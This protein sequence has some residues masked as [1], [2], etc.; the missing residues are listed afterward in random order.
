MK[1]PAYN[2]LYLPDMRKNQAEMFEMACIRHPE[3]DTRKLITEFMRSEYHR[4]IDQG[5][6]GW[7]NMPPGF[8]LKRYLNWSGVAPKCLYTD[9]AAPLDSLTAYWIGAIYALYQWEYAI[10]SAELVV[11][12]DVGDMEH[13]FKLLHT[14]GEVKAV[15]ILHER[16]TVKP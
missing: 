1:E 3:L 11:L 16:S 8:W 10:P 12:F 6:P 5:H 7:A 13:S 14:V 4:L 9:D 2:R 15:H